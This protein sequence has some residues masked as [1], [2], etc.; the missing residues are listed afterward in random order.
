MTERL[1]WT[2]LT[3]SLR[4]IILEDACSPWSFNFLNCYLLLSSAIV[5]AWSGHIDFFSLCTS[6]PACHLYVGSSE[7]YISRQTC[8]LFET[9]FRACSLGKSLH[10]QTLFS[11]FIISSFF[12][13]CSGFCH[14][15]KWIS[16]G[17]TCV[18]IIL[19][20]MLFNH[21]L[22]PL[23]VL[24]KIVLLHQLPK[25]S[26]YFLTTF[27]SK[28]F[29][30][31]NFPKTCLSSVSVPLQGFFDASYNLDFIVCLQVCLY[32]L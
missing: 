24:K 10:I 5:I 20:Y 19:H 18:Q 17:F 12:F 22:A 31:E 14:T 25:N 8:H 9:S 6:F 28:P 1:N 3:K 32:H 4:T 27:Y 30:M 29:C 11:F 13:N 26:S 2:E 7:V 23:A 15:L 21:L 16:H